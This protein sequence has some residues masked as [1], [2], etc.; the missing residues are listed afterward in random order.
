ME[1][2]KLFEI[3][4]N[5]ELLAF[6]ND[7]LEIDEDASITIN[8]DFFMEIKENILFGKYKV[9]ELDL[10]APSINFFIEG[11]DDKLEKRILRYFVPPYIQDETLKKSISLLS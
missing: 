4:N 3:K 1:Y 7:S 8:I 6:S 10:I 9:E 5:E 11:E 2:K